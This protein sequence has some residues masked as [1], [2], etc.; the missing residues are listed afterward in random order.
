MVNLFS[1]GSRINRLRSAW[2]LPAVQALLLQGLAALMLGLFLMVY[3]RLFPVMPVS[4]GVAVIL[5]GAIAAFLARWRNLAGWWWVI[6]FCF[7]LALFFALALQL[8]PVMFLVAFLLFFVLYWHTFRTQVPYFP[9]SAGVW[10]AVA[11]LLPADRAIRMADIGSGLGGLVLNLASKREDSE[12]IGIELAPLPWFI[13]WVRAQFSQSRGRFIRADYADMDFS[14]FDVVFAYLSPAVMSAVWEK[15][16]VEMR[17]GSLLLS[18]EFAI[19]N[20]AADLII[21][22]ER[23]RTPLYAWYI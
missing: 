4:I 8:P 3:E 12:I 9:S 5:Q 14:R 10:D 22:T 19:E 11:Q 2:H 17:P 23:M 18:N 13:S 1:S 16:R 20:Q 21:Q 15:A 6:Q 7:P